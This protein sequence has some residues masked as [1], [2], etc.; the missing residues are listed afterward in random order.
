VKSMYVFLAVFIFSTFSAHLSLSADVDSNEFVIYSVYQGIYMGNPG[1]VNSKDYYVNMGSKH[2]IK[3]GTILEV[4]RRSPSYNLST[5]KLVRDIAFPIGLVKVIHVET[6]AAIARI[7][8]F[9][10]QE[11]T[12][13]SNP[14]A[15]I[16]GDLVRVVR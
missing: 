14:P 8:K 12:P 15:M 16:V 1:E 3:K 2:G 5:Q 4:V 10:P 7:E 11:S 13:V 6:D 9:F